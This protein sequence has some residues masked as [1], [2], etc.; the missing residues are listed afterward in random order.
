MHTI[1]D[2]PNQAP[3]EIFPSHHGENVHDQLPSLLD[4][5]ARQLAPPAP[6]VIVRTL[7]VRISH[8]ITTGPFHSI[9]ELAANRGF[10]L[11]WDGRFGDYNVLRFQNMRKR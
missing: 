6:G 8:A 9:M 3:W 5:L 11:F 7:T 2:I 1:Q 4:Y 10:E